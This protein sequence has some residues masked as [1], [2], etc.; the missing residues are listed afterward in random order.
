MTAIKLNTICENFYHWEKNTPDNIF[1][2]QPYGST[3]KD[4][5]Y[6]EAGIQIRKMV[7]AI[8]DLNLPE[9]SNI[10]MV[11]KNCAHWIMAD[12]AIAMSGHISVP[13]YATLVAD[14]LNQVLVHSQCKLLF[15]GKLDD[16]GSMEAGIPAD[17]KCIAFPAEYAGSPT[18]KYQDWDSFVANHEPDKTDFIPK[19]DDLFTI[20]YTSGTTGMP[21]GVMATFGGFVDALKSTADIVKLNISNPRFFSYLPLCHIAERNIVEAACIASGGTIFFAETLETFPKN[22]AFA[23]PTHFLA[24]PRIWSKFQLG[25]LG[26]MP[27]KK[28]DLLLKIPLISS[29]IKKKIKTGLGLSKAEVILTGA[30]PIPNSVVDWFGKLD[31][32][33]RNAYGMSENLGAHSMMPIGNTKNG[34]VGKPYP[35]VET[36]IDPETG[37]VQMKA[38][39]NTPGYYREPELTANLYQDGWLCTGDMGEVDSQG[40]LKI[41]G[42]VKD[43]FKTAKGEYVVP[44]ALELAF[45]TNSNV[46]QICVAGTGLPQPCALVVLSEIGKSI[47]NQELVNSLTE[48]TQSVNQL[49]KNYEHIKTILV[50]KE[51]WSVEN[52]MLTPTMKIKRNIVEAKFG[53]L[54]EDNCEK[55]ELVVFEP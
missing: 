1:L 50:L 25:I 31:I 24:V 18:H 53:K 39:W 16:F 41:T 54:M 14:Q 21:K 44:G 2:R 51:P 29:L 40:F 3:W 19:L 22:L 5:S 37:E 49:V 34:T 36:R 47:D 35:G 12:L 32:R 42:R 46:E 55:N 43:Q 52:N 6:K 8:K 9:K 7:A 38:S 48:T 28:L 23:Q 30:A 33:I 26:K 15:I 11:S 45:A 13:F 4:Y 27:Q 20:I 17:L 10:G